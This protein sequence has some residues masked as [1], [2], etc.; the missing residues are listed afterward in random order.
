MSLPI[1]GTQQIFQ[2]KFITVFDTCFLD[3]DGG[4]QHWEWIRK[5]DVAAVLPITPEG[6]IVLIKNF[7]VPLQ[8]YVIEMPAGMI[9]SDESIEETARRELF[10]ETGYEAAVYSALPASPYA[11][12]V[13]NTALSL[14]VATGCVRK[15]GRVGDGTEDIT[16]LE[17]TPAE[18][19]KWYLNPEPDTFFNVRIFAAYYLAQQLKLIS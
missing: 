15:V 5:K 16:V 18:M 7:R 17:T 6:K 3:K 14:F 19:L 2:G 4:E 13:S 12:G 9:D 10:E 11:S 8:K 1:Q